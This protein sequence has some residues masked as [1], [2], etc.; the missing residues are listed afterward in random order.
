MKS[1]SP[2]NPDQIELF[3]ECLHDQN[4][5]NSELVRLSYP[6][7]VRLRRSFARLDAKCL[8]Q[9]NRYGYDW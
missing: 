7:G 8:C 3:R 1:H 5:K 6:L 9:A 4:K 2:Q